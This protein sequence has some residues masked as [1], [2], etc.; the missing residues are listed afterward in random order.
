LFQEDF[1]TLEQLLDYQPD[2]PVVEIVREDLD[3]VSELF[4]TKMALIL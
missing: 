2:G 1:D 4:A 3:D